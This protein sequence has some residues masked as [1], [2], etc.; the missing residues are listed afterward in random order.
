MNLALLVNGFPDRERPHYGVFNQRAATELSK[1]VHLTVLV[2]MAMRPGR[3]RVKEE[4]HEG[5][6]VMRVA[7]PMIPGMDRLNL[8]LFHAFLRGPLDSCLKRSD[9][10]H[11]VGVEFAG[12]LAAALGR[13]HDYCHVTQIIND[14]RCLKRPGFDRYPF[15]ETLR[16][17]VN[18]IVCNSRAL[19]ETAR[20]FFPGTSLV[21]T[22]Y[23][24]ADLACFSPDGPRAA[25]LAGRGIRFLFIGGIPAYSGRQYGANT[26]GG[27]T[28]MD[29]WRR[30]E[31][32]LAS[33]GA[34]LFFGGPGSDGGR[35]SGWRA[36]LQHPESVLVG[37]IVR[38]Q[39][40]PGYLRAADMVLIPSLEEG[41][42]NV[43]FEALASGRAVVGSDIGP[44]VEIL[45]DGQCGLTVKAGDARAWED[46][47]VA[48]A[49]PDGIGRIR[50]MGAAARKRA[51]TLYDHRDYARRLL[52]IY[53]EACGSAG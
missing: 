35:V 52:E 23:R 42:P 18:G 22:A 6:S 3:L 41:C 11:S 45:G 10:V 9:I 44:L 24:G 46:A 38:P 12:L 51:E 36:T 49:M 25:A 30:A 21:R 32:R 19:E 28:L 31:G 15:L 33:V 8:R 29:A 20:R 43:A 4:E 14:L 47:L 1:H 2:P 13:R 34:T 7:A 5:I 37:G 27:L 26:K 39:D 53:R 48:L 17:R 40:V 16:E 50:A